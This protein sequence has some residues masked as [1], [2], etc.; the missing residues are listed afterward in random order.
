MVLSVAVIPDVL[1]DGQGTC[2]PL[3]PDAAGGRPLIVA[4]TDRVNPP[5][6]KVGNIVVAGFPVVHGAGLGVS[7]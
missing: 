1:T 3:A 5:P 7:E 2:M 4:P 6:S